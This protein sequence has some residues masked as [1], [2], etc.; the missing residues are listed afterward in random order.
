MEVIV[1]NLFDLLVDWMEGKGDWYA[2]IGGWRDSK[3]LLVSL[4]ILV[5]IH[6][7]LHQPLFN[8]RRTTRTTPLIKHVA[9]LLN[10]DNVIY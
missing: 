9:L 4:T 3:R 2:F 7:L 6:I 1:Y 10:V 5:R 8:P